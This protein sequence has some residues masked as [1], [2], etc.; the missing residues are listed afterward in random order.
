MS[1]GME[2]V[3]DDGIRVIGKE[4]DNLRFISKVTSYTTS[5]YNYMYYLTFTVTSTEFPIVYLYIPYDDVGTCTNTAYTDHTSCLLGGG[6][7]TWTNNNEKNFG[8]VHNIYNT[9]GNTWKVT[10]IGAM[11]GY[12]KNACIYVFNTVGSTASSDTYGFRTYKADGATLAF[13]SG[14]TP[15]MSRWGAEFTSLSY[16]TYGMSGKSFT[17]G[18]WSTRNVSKPAFNS[19]INSIAYTRWCAGFCIDG[20]MY[21]YMLYYRMYMSITSNGVAIWSI[22]SSGRGYPNLD[23]VTTN[24]SCNCSVS[25]FA[26]AAGAWYGNFKTLPFIDGA[27]Y[28]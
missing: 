20:D 28:D 8:A 26:G 4:E 17:T 18:D 9:S 27:D 3:N 5:V 24:N 25:P 16:G 14:F 23:Y 19:S 22:S 11:G 13:D 15:L 10:V 6:H 21:W 2:F 1:Y 12:P 7:W